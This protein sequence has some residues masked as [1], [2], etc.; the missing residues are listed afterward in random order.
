MVTSCP[1]V[2]VAKNVLCE[3]GITKRSVMDAFGPRCD[4]TSPASLDRMEGVG[5][6]AD[7]GEVLG[8][9][10]RG[11][12]GSRRPVYISVGHRVSLR[13]AVGLVAECCLHSRIPEPI[14]QADLRTRAHVRARRVE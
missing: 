5:L 1:T 4:D 14:R 12:K 2:G 6:V 13:T 7:T 11:F 10:L 3:G 9:A 8:A